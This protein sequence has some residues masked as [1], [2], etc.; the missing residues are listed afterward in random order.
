MCS[1]TFVSWL[2]IPV[3][4]RGYVVSSVNEYLWSMLWGFAFSK[5]CLFLCN[6][7]LV[8]GESE[9]AFLFSLWSVHI[10]KLKP[11]SLGLFT[12]DDPKDA[13]S[14]VLM[15]KMLATVS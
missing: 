12:V 13:L 14:V 15:N 7:K 10:V 8:G 2:R 1:D 6:F 3:F 4:P 11:L 9:S 5:H